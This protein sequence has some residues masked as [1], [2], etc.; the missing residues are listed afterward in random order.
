M[1]GGQEHGA[2]TEFCPTTPLN[3]KVVRRGW[4]F[5][6]GNGE[7]WTGVGR[8]GTGLFRADE[9]GSLNPDGS[10]SIEAP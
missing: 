2:E 10:L 6:Y 4:R 3:A 8:D 7:L 1:G 5:N 9:P